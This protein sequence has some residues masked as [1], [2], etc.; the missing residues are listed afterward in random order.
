MHIGVHTEYVRLPMHIEC[1]KNIEHIVFF[2]FFES[3]FLKWC[4]V[5]CVKSL[6]SLVC[7]VNEN[8]T[9]CNRVLKNVC[10]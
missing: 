4:L 7:L 10:L 5:L 3:V 2:S 6:I 8:N 9:L 1:L